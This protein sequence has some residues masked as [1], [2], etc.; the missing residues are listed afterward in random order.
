MQ[1]QMVVAGGVLQW[2]AW[3]GCSAAF[4]SL[5]L[6]E[7]VLE[8]YNVIGERGIVMK[9]VGLYPRAERTR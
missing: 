4:P 8:R 7:N 6:L 1:K 3:Q 2:T 5:E 9:I